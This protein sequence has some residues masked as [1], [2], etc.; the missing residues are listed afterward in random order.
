MSPKFFINTCDGKIETGPC[1][2][3]NYL[4]LGK[5]HFYDGK[6]SAVIILNNDGTQQGFKSEKKLDSRDTHFQ[7]SL[8][9]MLFLM[10]KMVKI[11]FG[12][13]MNYLQIK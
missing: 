6:P 12:A 11:I 8:K 3:K 10:E 7:I 13:T 4:W 1:K 2:N 5:I 9:S